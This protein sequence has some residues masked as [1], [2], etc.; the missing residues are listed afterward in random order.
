MKI[1][2]SP[3]EMY[4][5]IEKNKLKGKTIGLVPTMGA[6]HA[7]HLSLIKEARRQN[8]IVVVSIFV[9]PLQFG[10]KE[11]FKR[12]PRPIN[13]DSLLCKKEGVDFIF[14]PHASQLYAKD[15]SSYV[16]VDKLSGILCGKY[17]PGHFTGVSTVVIKLFNIVNPDLAYFGQKDALQAAIIKRMALDLN[18]HVKIKIMPIV[19]EKTGL[20]LSSRNI[21]LNGREKTDA[22]VLNES[23]NLAKSLI[24]RGVRAP[25]EIINIMKQL[26]QKKDTAKIEYIDIVEINSLERIKK[27]TGSCLIALALWI[28]KTRLIDNM[29]IKSK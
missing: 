20:A 21:Y 13:K 8:D 12:Y 25:G 5:V 3:A 27:I 15:F 16:I 17:R 4:R 18:I 23:L 26:I 24:N 1:I 9:N 2:K 6:L 29:I 19:R 10:P 11:D 22:L 28:G 7:G 14:Y